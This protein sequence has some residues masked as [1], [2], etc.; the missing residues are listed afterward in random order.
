[1]AETTL[2]QTVVRTGWGLT[3]AGTRITLYHI[4]DYVTA[5]WSP[6]RIQA[7][8]KFT[9][10][11]IA[12]IMDY[13][14]THRDEVEA[15]YAEVLRLAEEDRRY[16]EER[17]RERFAQIAAMPPRTD[18]PEARAKLRALKDRLGIE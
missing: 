10:E 3:I 13:I 16:W 9:D 8:Y 15:E 11:Q 5:G 6:D 1:M 2:Q 17:N 18:H 4:M 12:D 14:E 7:L